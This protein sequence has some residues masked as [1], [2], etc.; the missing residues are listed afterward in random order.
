MRASSEDCPRTPRTLVWLE[1]GEQGGG[2][3]KHGTW[4]AQSTGGFA[5]PRTES[6]QASG[7]VGGLQ[8]TMASRLQSGRPRNTQRATAVL[9]VRTGAAGTKLPAEGVVSMARF[10]YILKA[11][12]SQGLLMNCT[13]DEEKHGLRRSSSGARW[14]CCATASGDRQEQKPQTRGRKARSGLRVWL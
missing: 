7:S 9:Q 4:Q 14:L 1:W 13:S 11:Q 3:G 8:L 2:K 10:R 6:V 5:L 12:S